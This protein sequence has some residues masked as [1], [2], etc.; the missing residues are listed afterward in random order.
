MTTHLLVSYD[1]RQLSPKAR[2]TRV[3]MAGP[4]SVVADVCYQT[5]SGKTHVAAVNHSK[6]PIFEC[7]L[8]SA[9]R[10]LRNAVQNGP[11]LITCCRCALL[12]IS[13]LLRDGKIE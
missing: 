6:D 7:G 5:S 9:S 3:R 1:H 4:Y 11:T 10:P 13:R 2:A 8:N 12:A